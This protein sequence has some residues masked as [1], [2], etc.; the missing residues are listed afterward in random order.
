MA[1]FKGCNVRDS[2]VVVV[3]TVSGQGGCHRLPLQHEG[4]RT[5]DVV[6]AYFWSYVEATKRGPMD[7][8]SS[9]PS[10]EIWTPLTRI[11]F[12]KYTLIQFTV[13]H[14]NVLQPPLNAVL[15]K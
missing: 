7:L 1:S 6:V 8:P 13:C 4:A 15:E 11:L 5:G 14:S 10:I 3:G 9:R 12:H 2:G